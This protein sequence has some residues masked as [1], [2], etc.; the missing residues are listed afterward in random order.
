MLNLRSYNLQMMK[1]SELLKV[2]ALS[3]S[4]DRL[5]I[6]ED[7]LLQVNS[8]TNEEKDL[9]SL[10]RTATHILSVHY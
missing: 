2:L 3:N 1:S 4:D 10:I 7:S 5:E 8:S 6:C 9:S